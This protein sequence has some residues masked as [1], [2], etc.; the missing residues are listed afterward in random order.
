MYMGKKIN[1]IYADMNERGR[2]VMMVE[3]WI[4]LGVIAIT[5]G[6]ALGG[7]FAYRLLHKTRMDPEEECLRNRSNYFAQNLK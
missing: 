2:L 4:I 1:R 6:I 7:V 5:E 3:K